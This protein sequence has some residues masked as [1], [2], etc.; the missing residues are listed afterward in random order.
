MASDGGVKIFTD[1]S[2][3]VIESAINVW[4]K[5]DGTVEG[6]KKNISQ[7]PAITWDGSSYIVLVTYTN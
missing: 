2:L 5:G 3:P 7:P 4:L 6:R 1:A